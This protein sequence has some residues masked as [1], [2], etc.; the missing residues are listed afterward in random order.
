VFSGKKQDP[1]IRLSVVIPVYNEEKTVVEILERVRV[2]SVAGVEFE[3]LV[4]DDGSTDGTVA[5][6]E[7]RS[8]LYDRLI[9]MPRNGGKGA[10]VK[11]A[12]AEAA[13]DFVLFQDA[14]LEYDPGE[15]AKLLR[16]VIEFDA[17]VVMG[18]RFLAPEYTRVHY[19]LH[20]V[21]NRLITFIFNLLN[22][23]TF[24]DVYSCYLL[25]RR[26]LV[27]PAQLVSLGWE[28]H[29]E[30]LSRAVS[31]ARA[32]YEVPISYHGRGYDEGKK[33]KGRHAIAVIA[34]IVRRR[35]SR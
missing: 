14:D 35:F 3:V 18:S 5:L 25:Y 16:P 22:N 13:G 20:K 9:R 29:A 7:A 32:L 12:L 1:M 11:A 19:F 23:T 27:D 17:D 15:Y 28:Q 2:Q 6:L 26:S 30:I 8:E 33:I 34:M 21:G 4:V 31:G 10:A 24:T